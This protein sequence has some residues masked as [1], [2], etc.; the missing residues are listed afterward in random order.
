MGRRNTQNDPYKFN[1]ERFAERRRFLGLSLSDVQQRMVARGT[2]IT[3]NALALWE[4][5]VTANPSPGKVC[6]ASAVLGVKP[7]FFYEQN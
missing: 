1:A 4:T 2:A 7:V 5:G 6:A 3:V